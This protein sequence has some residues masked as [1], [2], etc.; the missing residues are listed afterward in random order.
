PS[1]IAGSSGLILGAGTGVVPSPFSTAGTT[2]SGSILNINALLTALQ[3]D[4][5]VNV[6]STPQILATNFQKARIVVGQNVPF[7]VGSTTTPGGVIQQN[8]DRKDVGVSLEL[9]PEVLENKRVKLDIRQE[10]S[11][12]VAT[13]QGVSQN[14]GPTTNKR[15]A[16]TSVIVDD[17]QTIVIGGLIQ[18]NYTKT[19][20]K[21]PFLGDIPILGW[22]FRYQTKSLDKD[23]LMIFLTPHIMKDQEQFTKLEN[24]KIGDM[25]RFIEKNKMEKKE[26]SPQEIVNGQNIPPKPQ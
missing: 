24:E 14:L 6:L 8:I 7:P 17:Q 5:D 15:E 1:A 22:L 26:K 19:E 12:V 21:V 23:N 20:N 4:S 10:I 2:A 25:D 3:A 11:S 16:T 18:D 9:T 13:A